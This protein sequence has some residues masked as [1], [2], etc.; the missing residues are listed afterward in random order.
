MLCVG[1]LN[2]IDK[3]KNACVLIDASSYVLSF[4]TRMKEF[5]GNVKPENLTLIEKSKMNSKWS[6]SGLQVSKRFGGFLLSI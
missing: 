2:H 5:I 1:C 3:T 4:D 6:E